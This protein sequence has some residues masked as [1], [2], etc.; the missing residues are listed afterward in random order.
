M[1]VPTVA[2]FLE[3]LQ[4]VAPFSKAFGWDPVGLQ[5]GDPSDAATRVAVAHEATE[6]VV[7]ALERDPVQL[8]IL[9]HPLIFQ[10]VGSLVAGPTATGRAYRLLRAG[11]AVAV[12]HTAFDVTAGGAADALAAAAGLEGFHGFGPAWG[13]DQVKFAV[14]VPAG[15]SDDVAEAMAASGAGTIGNYSACS[16]RSEGIG[17]F[18]AGAGTTPAAGESEKLN[19]EAEIRLEMIAPA[20][21]KDAVASALVATHPYEEPA[22]DVYP[23]ESNAAMLGRVGE[24]PEP[25]PLREFGALLRAELG[26]VPRIAGNLEATV[27]RVAVVPGSGSSLLSRAGSGVDVFVTGDVSHHRARAALDRGM[28]VIDAGH[29]PT[30]RPGVLRLYAAVARL[31]ANAVDLTEFDPD[32]WRER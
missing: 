7:S 11:V 24:L 6:A 23:V 20:V 10:P 18:F 3:A 8:L 13:G 31:S 19:R 17:T 1:S 26:G 27:G 9:Y 29:A 5:L 32:P 28:A 2:S 15:H 21:H 4:E 25:L 12:V 16:F 30:E 22:Y 14:F